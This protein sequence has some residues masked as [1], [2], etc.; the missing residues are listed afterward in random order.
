MVDREIIKNMKLGRFDQNSGIS[1][2]SRRLNFEKS[3]V[4][5]S[6]IFHATFIWITGW[7]TNLLETLTTFAFVVI[8]QMG[9]W[10]LKNGW[11][12]KTC[13]M[14]YLEVKESLSAD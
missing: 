2:S 12:I 5:I 4:R 6:A 9:G 3:W 1:A 7:I 10:I 8:L 13:S 11:L 14:G